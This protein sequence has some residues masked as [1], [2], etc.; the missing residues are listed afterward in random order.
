MCVKRHWNIGIEIIRDRNIG[1]EKTGSV[2][3]GKWLELLMDRSTFTQRADHTLDI[4][5]RGNELACFKFLKSISIL[6]GLNIKEI[7]SMR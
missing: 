7:K 6:I 2:E 3:K 5:W 4:D 1:I